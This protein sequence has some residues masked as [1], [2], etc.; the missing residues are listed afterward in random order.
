MASLQESYIDCIR[1]GRGNGSISSNVVFGQCA[2]RQFQ[3]GNN[4]AIGYCSGGHCLS[5][6]NVSIGSFAG[7]NSSCCGYN[8]F[9]GCNAGRHDYGPYAFKSTVIGSNANTQCGSLGMT[10]I[11][12]EANK[13]GQLG[14][15][16]NGKNVII[17]FRAGCTG[18]FGYS[19]VVIGANA[20]QVSDG[21]QNTAIGYRAR[22]VNTSGFGNTTI[23]YRGH[24]YSFSYYNQTTVGFCTYQFVNYNNIGVIGRAGLCKAYVYV[25]WTNASDSRDKNDIEYIDDNLSL[26]LIRKLKPVSFKMDYRKSYVEKCG[27]EFGQKDGTLKEQEESYGFIAQEIKQSAD[28]LNIDLDLVSY[29]E[30]QDSWSLTKMDILPFVVGSIKRINDELDCIEKNLK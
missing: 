30:F 20:L 24:E 3:C 25:G 13:Y 1:I 27:F 16:T 22:R 4:V 29:N 6:N 7:R 5:L 19:N 17:G 11:G 28:E 9:I 15:Y 10:V 26:N 2:G 21:S 18:D 12:F 23:G 14:G 8:V